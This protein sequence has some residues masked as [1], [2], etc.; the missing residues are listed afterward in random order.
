MEIV[1]IPLKGALEHK[2]N[3]GRNEIIRTGDVQIMSAGTGIA[4]SEYN[5]SETEA[6]NFLQIWVFPEKRN[7]PPRYEQ[8]TFDIADRENQFQV[9]VSPEETPV[10]FGSTRMPGFIGKAEKGLITRYDV[11][12]KIMANVFIIEGDVTINGQSLNKRDGLEIRNSEQLSVKADSD[13][14]ILLIEVPML[15]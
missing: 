1:S 3:T 11:H 5:A 12:R 7:I 14:E 13:A 6:V 10:L 4:H 8:K 15:T 2:D 9:V